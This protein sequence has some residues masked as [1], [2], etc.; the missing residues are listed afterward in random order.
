MNREIFLWQKADW[1]HF[2][3]D[4]SAL[5]ETLA[6]VHKL[7][8]QLAGSL[9]ILGFDAQSKV[10]VDAITA[11]V[12]K[13]S[14]IEGEI[15]N[16]DSLRSSIARK[17]GVDI[18]DEGTT[19]HYIE[20]LVQVFMDA[21]IGF[22]KELTA[23]R[24]FGWHAA[25]FPIGYSGSYRITVADWRKGEDAMQVISGPMGKEKIHYEA[26]PSSTV[27]LMMQ[28]FLEWAN[29]RQSIDPIVKAAIAHLWF[30]SIH[31]FD[32]GNGRL[33][34]TITDMFLARADG[35]PHRYYS[36]SAQICKEKKAY[37]DILEKTQKGNLEVTSWLQWFVSIV[38]EALVH[39]IDKMQTTLKKHHYW[40][41]F[42]IVS[43]NERQKKIVNMLWDGFEGKLSTSKYSKIAKCSQD[44]ALRDLQDLVAKGMLQDSGEGGRST[45]YI[46]REDEG[47]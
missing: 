19:D 5:V 37:Y 30:V 18:P 17:L 32:D 13:S 28:D 11:E 15:I 16:A 38:E 36:V 43:I 6:R 29:G 2:S 46:L 20:G 7:Q 41:H 8:G 39:A 22:E 40:Q 33:T 21:S 25:L 35:M 3:W 4:D 44:T 31:P 1:P 10:Q 47:I 12:Q 9:S 34:R 24:I 26:P 45:N 27:P 14:E 42:N 23:E